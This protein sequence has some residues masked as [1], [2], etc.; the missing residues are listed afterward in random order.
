[1]E[2]N[3]PRAALQTAALP[4]SY[5]GFVRSGPEGIDPDSSATKGLC[6]HWWVGT[7]LNGHSLR[8]AF[9]V[10]WARQCPADPLFGCG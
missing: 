9:T 10:P 4:L 6:P 7:E 3:H 8:G 5:F 2:S 1:M